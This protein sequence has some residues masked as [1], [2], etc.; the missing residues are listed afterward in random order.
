M[1]GAPNTDLSPELLAH[2]QAIKKK[3]I[4]YG[5]DFFEVVYEVLDFATMNQIAAFGAFRPGIRTGS[6]AW[7]M[8]A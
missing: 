2:M 1:P 5:L 6:G 8:T 3:A 7:S 4:E